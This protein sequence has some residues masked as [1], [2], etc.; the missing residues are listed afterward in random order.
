MAHSVSGPIIRVTPN[1]LH[2]RDSLFFD[3]VYA[4]NVHL[5]KEGW[6]K[7]FGAEHSVMTTVSGEL[8]KRRRA[9]LN[10]M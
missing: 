4:K 3:Q 8:H 5:N 2:I 10:P 1:E 9:A 7:R 6:D